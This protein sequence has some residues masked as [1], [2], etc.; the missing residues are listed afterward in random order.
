MTSVELI[1]QLVSVPHDTCA[2]RLAVMYT[3]ISLVGATTPT[4]VYHLKTH[5]AWRSDVVQPKGNVLGPKS[6][7]LRCLMIFRL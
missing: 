7:L 2:A 5:S 6:K 1:V 3:S 4:L